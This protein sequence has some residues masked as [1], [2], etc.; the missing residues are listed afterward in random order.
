MTSPVTKEELIALAWEGIE[1]FP[2]NAELYIRPMMYFEDGFVAPNTDSTQCIM[3]V[4]EARCLP[5]VV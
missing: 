3:T 4:F 2:K 5:G 1:K